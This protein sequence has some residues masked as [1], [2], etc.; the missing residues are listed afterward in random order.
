MEPFQ[1]NRAE[2]GVE[3]LNAGDY[4]EAS[5]VDCVHYTPE[6]HR[7]LGLAIAQKVREIL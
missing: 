4:A 7:N 2:N 1:L 6:A 5:P 3:Y